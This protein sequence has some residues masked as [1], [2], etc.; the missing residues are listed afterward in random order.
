MDGRQLISVINELCMKNNI[1]FNMH[2]CM[3]SSFLLHSNEKFRIK[4]LF[5][6]KPGL[7]NSFIQ[8]SFSLIGPCLQKPLLC[9]CKQ[10]LLYK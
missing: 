9:P 5:R 10:L 7:S 2:D 8:I 4:Y 1:A 6:K 3:S